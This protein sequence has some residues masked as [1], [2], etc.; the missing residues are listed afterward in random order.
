[1]RIIPNAE[2]SLS[3]SVCPLDDGVS[4]AEEELVADGSGDTAGDE[5]ALVEVVSLLLE[6]AARTTRTLDAA[7]ERLRMDIGFPSQ[8]RRATGRTGRRL[9]ATATRKVYARASCAVR[10][11]AER[12]PAGISPS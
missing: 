12:N 5:A 10:S 1:V 2:S 8:D 4:L 7:M 11:T 3:I 6:H 9:C